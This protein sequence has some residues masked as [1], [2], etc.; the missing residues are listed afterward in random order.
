MDYLATYFTD[1]RV[2]SWLITSFTYSN[3][4]TERGFPW[5]FLKV[6]KGN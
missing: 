3:V 2:N 5:C 6:Q 1:K 4:K